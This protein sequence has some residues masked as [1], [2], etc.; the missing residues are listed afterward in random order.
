MMTLDGL[1]R[2]FGLGRE[3]APWTSE[4]QRLYLVLVLFVQTTLD[5]EKL[6]PPSGGLAEVRPSFLGGAVD[7]F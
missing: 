1:F 3:K 6:L 2:L 5:A 7:S 4:S